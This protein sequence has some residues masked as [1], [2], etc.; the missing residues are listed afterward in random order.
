MALEMRLKKHEGS[1]PCK[2]YFVAIAYV[3]GNENKKGKIEGMGK[4]TGSVSMEA[5]DLAVP[6]LLVLTTRILTLKSIDCKHIPKVSFLGKR[7]V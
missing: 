2:A 4:Y 3:Q 1:T 5:P 6:S 7:E